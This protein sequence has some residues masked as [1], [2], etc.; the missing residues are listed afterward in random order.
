[1]VFMRS[2]ILFLIFITDSYKV[3]YVPQYSCLPHES[4][5]V[6]RLTAQTISLV[7]LVRIGI[8]I[9]RMPHNRYPTIYLIHIDWQQM[10]SVYVSAL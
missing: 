2:L 4:K 3:V 8:C 5:G 7:S 9:S 6:S 1:M 10:E